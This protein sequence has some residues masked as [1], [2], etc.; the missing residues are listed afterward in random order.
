MQDDLMYDKRWKKKYSLKK[1]L[2]KCSFLAVLLIGIAYS[3]PYHEEPAQ[4]KNPSSCKG[5]HNRHDA[6]SRYFEHKGSP[7]PRR[8]ATAVLET[9][10]PRLMAKIAVTETNANPNLR[11]YGYKKRHSGA[12]GV[13]ERDWGEVSDNPVDQALQ[14]ERALKEFERIHSGNIEK[15]LNNYGGDKTKRTYAQNILKDLEEIP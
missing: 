8:M 14:S 1:E 4:L 15:A 13:A 10:R 12:F 7:D 11:K 3:L 6:M 5:C 9:S 2:L